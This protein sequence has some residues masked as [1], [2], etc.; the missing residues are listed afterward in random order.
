MWYV[1]MVICILNFS[2]PKTLAEEDWIAIIRESRKDETW[3][4]INSTRVCSRHFPDSSYKISP[5][6]LRM[7]MYK[8]I[9]VEGTPY[10]SHETTFTIISYGVTTFFSVYIFICRN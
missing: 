10:N 1:I 8:A 9:P 7:L 2:I 6:G 5:K 3:V 4:P